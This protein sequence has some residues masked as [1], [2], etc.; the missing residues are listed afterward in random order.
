M[1]PAQF[2]PSTWMLY[3]DRIARATGKNPPN[4][5]LPQTAFTASAIFLADLGADRGTSAAEREAALRYFAGG[6]WKNP[7]SSAAT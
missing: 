2:I 7:A 1:G 4:P 5:W 6:N 3:K